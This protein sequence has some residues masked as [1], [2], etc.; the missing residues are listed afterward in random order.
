MIEAYYVLQQLLVKNRQRLVGAHELR[1]RFA[2]DKWKRKSVP[3]RLGLISDCLLNQL[4]MGV[5]RC[6]IPQ[7]LY[8]RRAASLEAFPLVIIQRDYEKAIIQISN[9]AMLPVRMPG[10]P[11]TLVV[12]RYRHAITYWLPIHEP[13]KLKDQCHNSHRARDA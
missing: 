1:C 10:G 4:D 5:D 6:D 13:T 12:T 2:D 7:T 9:F 8:Q 3:C 11:L